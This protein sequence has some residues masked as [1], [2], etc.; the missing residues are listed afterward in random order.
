MLKLFAAAIMLSGIIII[1]GCSSTTELQKEAKPEHSLQKKLIGGWY[2]V[3]FEKYDQLKIDS[4]IKSISE[5]RVKEVTITYDKNK[6]LAQK[7]LAG[8][9]SKINF[10]VK[11]DHVELKDGSAKYINKYLV[12]MYIL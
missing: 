2:P 7:I 8:I 10:A 12:H 1:A 9:Q 4:I 3:F 5:G 11:M 6:I